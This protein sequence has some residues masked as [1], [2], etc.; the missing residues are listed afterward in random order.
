MVIFHSY[1][2]LPKGMILR[3]FP[4]V[5]Y[6]STDDTGGIVFDGVDLSFEFN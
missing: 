3:K 4:Q 2:R 5:P 1:A 6:I